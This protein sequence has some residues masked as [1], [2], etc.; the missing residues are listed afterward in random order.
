LYPQEI[1]QV[2]RQLPEVWDC[3]VVGF[4]DP[5]FGERPVAFVVADRASGLA[6]DAL[7]QRLTEH[8][9]QQLGRLKRPDRFEFTNELPYS[10]SGKVLRRQLRASGS[11]HTAPQSRR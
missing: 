7:R 6:P 3:A 2:L 8:C 1:E 11:L 10:P 5:E 9:A 4:P